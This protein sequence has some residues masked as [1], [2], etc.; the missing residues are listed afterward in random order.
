MI[1]NPVFLCNLAMETEKLLALDV[2]TARLEVQNTGRQILM[3][4]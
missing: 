1:K 4:C 2:N 3:L